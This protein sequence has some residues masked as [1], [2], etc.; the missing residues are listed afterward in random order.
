MKRRGTLI[1]VFAT[2]LTLVGSGPARAT[3]PGHN[4]LMLVVRT[5]GNPNWW[6]LITDSA[7]NGTSFTDGGMD[8]KSMG[9]APNG[10]DLVYIS[11]DGSGVG[12]LRTY[13]Y[14]NGS[15]TNWNPIYVT[16]DNSCPSWTSDGKRILFSST[17]DGGGDTEILSVRP[18]GTGLKQLTHNSVNEDCPKMSPNGK[19]I[20]IQRDVG[21]F[22]PEI[23]LLHPNGSFYKRLTHNTTPDMEPEWSPDSTRV[24]YTAAGPGDTNIAT[25]LAN[26]KGR[27]V[28]TAGSSAF[29]SNPVWSPNGKLIAFTRN[30]G[31][32]P[33]DVWVMNAS[34]GAHRHD[35]S[36]VVSNDLM[37]A[38]QP[39]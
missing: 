9:W 4:G 2:A 18:D 33:Y 30:V 35:W 39:R 15:F 8:D 5:T 10:K 13:R 34:T 11:E 23:V 38:W 14:A 16:G 26:G 17:H 27:R 7:G 28:L 3:F 24:A 29:E 25:V 20:A 36:S 32:G 22:P 12:S 19:W 1:V 21:G 37:P 31:S 6:V